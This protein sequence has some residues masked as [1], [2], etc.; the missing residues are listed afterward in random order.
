MTFVINVLLTVF[1]SDAIANVLELIVFPI[2]RFSVTDNNI[3]VDK[4]LLNVFV[5]TIL[6]T[7]NTFAISSFGYICAI[8]V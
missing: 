4:V 5:L 1:L 8:N 6:A 7:A 2:V 3:F